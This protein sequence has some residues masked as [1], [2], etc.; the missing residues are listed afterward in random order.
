MY[1]L[2][3]VHT[4]KDNFLWISKKLLK[5]IWRWKSI[6]GNYAIWLHYS[7]KKCCVKK[8]TM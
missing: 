7:V 2:N 1:V 5:Y 8:G 3:Y 4:H 6:N